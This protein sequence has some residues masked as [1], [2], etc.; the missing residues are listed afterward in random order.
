M[1]IE[2]GETL[3]GSA[4]I[5]NLSLTNDG[6]IIAGPMAP[7]VIKPNVNGETFSGLA[8]GSFGFEN[9]GSVQVE[10]GGDLVL[11]TTASQA[12]SQ[13]PVINAGT[14]TVNDGGL[15]EVIG[16]AG[17]TVSLGNLAFFG[18]GIN[19]GGAGFGG[20]LEFDGSGATFDLNDIGATLGG[21]PFPGTLMLS[22]DSGNLITGVTG[23][24]TLV[25]DMGE[26]ISGA[27]TIENLDLVNKG[28]IIADGTNALEIAPNAGGFTNSGTV[29]VNS[30]STLAVSL[31]QTAG[32][33]GF[34]NA[35]TVNVQDGGTLE[36]SDLN[37]D[38]NTVNINNFQVSINLGQSTALRCFSTAS[39]PRTPSTFSPTMAFSRWAARS[40]WRIQ[41][42]HNTQG[43]LVSADVMVSGESPIVGPFTRP[44]PV[45]RVGNEVSFVI[46]NASH[47][48]DAQLVLT[49]TTLVGYD[50]GPLEGAIVFG[51]QVS[52]NPVNYAIWL[53]VP[54]TGKLSPVPEPGSLVLFGTALL[55]LGVVF[56]KI[57]NRFNE[58][59]RNPTLQVF[60]QAA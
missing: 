29:Q 21:E 58:D 51:P 42:S 14:I 27:G 56:R 32:G 59:W 6:T 57:F 22:D 20:V 26:T 36:F 40:R 45:G 44:N 47:T 13:A 46:A 15:V 54:G 17:K 34:S 3:Q 37:P 31:V 16:A 1:V 24:E 49:A 2:S 12:A 52:A 41:P 28:A 60:T 11:D 10:L 48:N 35:G 50:G 43:T 33:P 5:S 53:T 55:G 30:G 38:T 19:I 39:A 18:A 7:L 9:I 25:N 23:T 4:T 8:A